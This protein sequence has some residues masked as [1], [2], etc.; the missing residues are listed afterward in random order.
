M[1]AGPYG[2][3]YTE[4]IHRSTS[5]I[6]RIPDQNKLRGIYPSINNMRVGPVQFTIDQKILKSLAAEFI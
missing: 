2:N 5:A 4:P 6:S 3:L 1:K